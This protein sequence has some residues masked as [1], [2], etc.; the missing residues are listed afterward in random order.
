M[1]HLSDA[2]AR[3]IGETTFDRNVVVLA[4][5]GT[6]KTTLLVNR[7]LHA[8]LREPDALRLTEILA[9][10]FTNK[11]ANE[12]KT[13]LR[14]ILSDLLVV[15]RSSMTGEQVVDVKLEEFQDRYGLS[16]EQIQDRLT[17]AL[18]DLEKTHIGTLHSFA[19][20]VLRLYPLESGVDPNFQEDD[21]TRFAEIFSE[22]WDQWIAEELQEKGTH[23]VGWKELL[24]VVDLKG[25]REFARALCDD[26]VNLDE[27][28][29]QLGSVIR[30]PAIVTWLQINRKASNRL[31]DLYGQSNPRKIERMLKVAEEVFHH[32]TQDSRWSEVSFPQ[33][34][35]ALLSS[36]IGQAPK[37]WLPA[38]FQE[39][40]RIIRNAR[41]LLQVDEEILRKAVCLLVPVV[42]RVHRT[43]AE[44][45][46]IRFDGLI[47]HVRDLLRDY[48]RI[49][50][51]LK[52]SFQAIM[53]DEFQDTD[54]LQY[55]ILLYLGEWL[56][57]QGLD[58]KA[59]R[60]F[61]G[62]LFIV[63]DPKQSIYA[64]RRADI[65]A[66]DH[67]VRQ[68]TQDGGEICTLA[69]N[70]RSSGA[71][72]DV[73][74]ALFDRLFVQ[75]DQV[76]PPN[77]PLIAAR[78]SEDDL[79]NFGV[80]LY[81]MSQGTEEEWD[82]ERASRLEAEWLAGW[83]EQQLAGGRQHVIEHGAPVPL[84]PGHI[85][86]LFRK[87]TNV[88]LYVEA[89]HRRGL[90]FVTDGE[91]HFYRRQEIIDL[92]NVLR[93][94]DNPADAMALVGILRSSLGGITDQEI[95][96][97]ARLGPLAIH[98]RDG[99]DEWTSSRKPVI[100]DLFR[101]LVD[102]HQQAQHVPVSSMID[103][104]LTQLPILELAAASSHGEQAVMNIWKLRDLVAEQ[105]PV[106]HLS[107]S[108]C[109]E[110]LVDRL[111]TH[112]PEP[113]APLAEE[114]LDAV[115][116]LSI[117]KAKGLEFP[118]VVLPGL[119]HKAAGFD[120]GARVTVDWMSSVN[121]CRFPP[122]WNTGQVLLWE[123]ERIREQ[124]EQRRV[125][126]VGMTRA[127]DR[128]VL[129]GGW[130][131]TSF[132]DNFLGLFQSVA[133]G[134]IG[135]PQDDHVHIG[136]ATIRQ[137]VVTS[138]NLSVSRKKVSVPSAS[139]PEPVLSTTALEEKDNQR[140]SNWTEI[141]QSRAFVTPSSLMPS[142]NRS[143][144]EVQSGYSKVSAQL[145]GTW[146][147]RFL[148]GWDFQ[149][150]ACHVSAELKTFELQSF[151]ADGQNNHKIPLLL[152]IQQMM[153]TFCQSAS[154][155]ELQRA[156]VIGREVPFIMPWAHDRSNGLAPETC[157]MEGV[158]D[159]V[160]ET[161]GEVWVGEY[162][163]DRVTDSDLIRYAGRHRTQA[164]IYTTAASQTL[165][166]AVKGCK[167]FFLRMGKVVT[168]N[169]E[170]ATFR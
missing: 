82:A 58:W 170:S 129:S 55:E 163:T 69:T 50:E 44:N 89:L 18:D 67:V 165:G 164:E 100:R 6:G 27:L 115:R 54:P 116:V 15:S 155:Q 42:Q 13:R 83:L 143:A 156:S 32:L 63:G 72:L 106:P 125:L 40:Q 60:L 166:R 75:E 48:P 36:A 78:H 138:S 135:N 130:P 64:F 61:P 141:V 99:W 47:V 23:H 39:A 62:K 46:W 144:S 81:V 37:G 24:N 160:Y 102:L 71:V 119:H 84:R 76:Q 148:E 26:V 22:V 51:E 113:E 114:T 108:G 2:E 111:M 45:G 123:K 30:L 105:A 49:R 91:R 145:V 101:V 97:F 122:T 147:H 92:V 33:D 8:L 34:Q 162:K 80:D 139:K 169:H 4:G 25:I 9:L 11:A 149:M 12:M 95:T 152:D 28:Q 1:T 65:H 146:M 52:L 79:V 132:G 126:Y 153:E 5:A 53:V 128:L 142:W 85:A 57:E 98:R 158:I 133:D 93:V 10:T 31:L 94:L 110:R 90:P 70:F 157:V 74:N 59:I 167:L 88:H 86:V 20:H 112:P 96:E 14:D 103:Q 21:G 124:A 107:F 73:V 66:F 159:I 109:V 19:A 140:R 117:H 35:K 7:I 154:Y 41:R 131:T 3:Q 118:V 29:Q 137:K 68:L 150:T 120:Q 151:P 56:G 17:C 121:G 168:L 161:N 43:Y 77:V 38:D 16:R 127:R 136:A 104:V 134:D 87:F